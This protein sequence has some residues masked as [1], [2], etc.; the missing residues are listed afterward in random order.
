LGVDITRF[1]I[2]PTRFEIRFPA[3][4][5][6]LPFSTTSMSAMG[7]TQTPIQRLSLFYHR[8]GTAAGASV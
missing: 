1:R 5:K 6:I 3:R 7:P 8:P 4:I 2:L